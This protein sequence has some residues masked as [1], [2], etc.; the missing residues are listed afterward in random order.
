LLALNPD[1]TIHTY[2]FD[3]NAGNVIEIFSNYDLILDGTDRFATKLLINDACLKLHLP[4]VYAS[5]NQ[6]EGQTAVF[7]PKHAEGPC[8]RCFQP[9]AP[10]IA[11]ENCAQAGVIGPVVGMLGTHQALS[12][13]QVI[14]S[15][16]GPELSTLK[17]FDGL[18][19]EWMKLKIPKNP[20]CP[21][22]SK[23]L[24]EITLQD[25][26]DLVCE[27]SD[28]HMITAAELAK[29]Q[30]SGTCDYT[31]LDV[32]DT[33]EWEEYHLDGALHFALSR[34][35]Q[36]EFPVLPKEEKLLVYCQ[37]GK[38]SAKAAKILEAAGFQSITE[39]KAGLSEWVFPC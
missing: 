4:W 27:T 30:E 33:H 12:A 34:L 6:W 2:D 18:H 36:N 19:Q 23:P 20:N 5:V 8:Y 38:R 35:E 11:I 28:I 39:L 31:I 9:N 14:L 22:C 17:V 7:Q 21:A 24:N 16:G 25:D 15:L 26:P 32:R 37:A 13:L 1:L 3:L 10:K 29:L